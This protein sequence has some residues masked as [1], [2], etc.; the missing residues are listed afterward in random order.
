MLFFVML[1][2]SK[3]ELKPKSFSCQTNRIW[4]DIFIDNISN[5]FFLFRFACEC[6]LMKATFVVCGSVVLHV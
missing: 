2:F 6:L 1:F 5:T 3:S 4:K